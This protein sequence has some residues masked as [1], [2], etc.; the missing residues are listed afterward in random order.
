MDLTDKTSE[1]LAKGSYY[2]ILESI[3][4]VAIGAAFWIIMAKIIDPAS[5]GQVMVAI[6]FAT[7]VIGFA[8][9]GV[10]VTIS[11]YIAE[12]NARNMP[13]TADNVMKLGIKLALIVSGAAALCVALLS[14]HIA[15]IAYNDPSL[16]VLLAIAV[17]AYLPSQ[18][19]VIALMGAFQGHQRMEYSLITFLIY[20][21][22]RL[23]IAITLVLYGFSSFGI[24]IAF[25][26]SSIIAATVC[27]M[28]LIPKIVSKTNSDKEE[29][30]RSVG[31]IIKFSGMNY[32]AVGMRTLSAQMGVIILGT[33][34]FELAA[35]F[36]LSVMLA[37]VVG[38]VSTA[39]SRAV[40]PTAS[41]E[42][43]KGNRAKFK[44]VFN[45]TVRISLLL[46]GFSFI[47]FMIEPSHVLRLL[48]D[49]YL[50][51]SSALRILV[52]SAIINAIGTII[53]SML[54]AANRAAMVAKIGFLSATS[55]IVLTFLLVPAV[56]IDGAAIAILVG[57]LASL[58]P[59][60][61]ILKTKEKLTVS[62]KSVVKP[63]ISILVGLLTGYFL[64]V[65][66]DNFILALGLAVVLYAGFSMLYRVIT[67]NELKA[68]ITIVLRTMRA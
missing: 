64:Y 29:E 13:S 14:N 56:G 37:N 53:I 12:Y 48:S 20:E 61:I 25:S 51:A 54:N 11:K 34:D 67:Q 7:S 30:P 1:K 19:V 21:L 44:N 5:L 35:F 62:V 28:W 47:V 52:V 42:W 27:R 66:W 18:T 50:E 33:Q 8:G 23:A 38:G 49:S 32:F 4:N 63:S 58:I 60:V 36:G 24:I 46:S 65:L 68:L 41:E 9:Y 45:K 57:S 6:A 31:H 2:L 43:A 10:R 17:V 3:T 55:T 40:L 39:V 26:A 15:T 59:S 16:S 22:S